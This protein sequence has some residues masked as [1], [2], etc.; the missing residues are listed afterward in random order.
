MWVNAL[1]RIHKSFLGVLSQIRLL[2]VRC[3]GLRAPFSGW[4][5]GGIKWPLANLRNIQIGENVSLGANGW[6][7]LPLSNRTSRIEIGEGTAIGD[8]FV[9]SANELI[10]IGKR[11]LISWR[12]TIL[13]H[14]HVTGRGID[15]TKS[16]I[17]KGEPVIIGDNTYIGTG[18]VI[19]RGVSI[20]ENC[21]INA[22]S[23]VM[24]SFE[25]HCVISGSPAKALIKL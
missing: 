4:V 3:L 11:C 16:G 22:N 7:Y 8:N 23:V 12:V 5:G 24:R 25:D 20:G 14:D 18:V 13:D 19:L 6:F 1:R 21:V 15:P 2:P 17:T 9:I 10:K